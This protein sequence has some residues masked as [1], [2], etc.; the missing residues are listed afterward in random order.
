MNVVSAA[1]LRVDGRLPNEPRR[2]KMSSS[3]IGNQG[4]VDYSQGDTQIR[5]STCQ[6]KDKNQMAINLAF[7]DFARNEPMNERKIFEMKTK[8]TAIFCPMLLSDNQIDINVEVKQDDGSLFS[9]IVNGITLCLCYTGVTL[10]DMVLSVSMNDMLDLCTDEENKGYQCSMAY[11][12][13]YEKIIYFDC[14]GRSQRRALTACIIAGV[15][16]LKE[17]HSFFRDLLG[18]Q[19]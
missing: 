2:I 10:K 5:I 16:Y 11:S 14:N 8:L 7:S 15:D 18:S 9:V 17:L 4:I 3:I 19:Q 12:V 1:L 13:N 6:S